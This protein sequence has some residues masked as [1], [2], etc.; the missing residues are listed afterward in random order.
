MFALKA[1]LLQGELLDHFNFRGKKKDKSFP[2]GV[3]LSDLSI[4]FILL[5][6]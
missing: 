1:S 3:V 6:A 4:S 5:A 2:L